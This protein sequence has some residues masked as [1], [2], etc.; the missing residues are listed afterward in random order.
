MTPYESASLVTQWISAV[1]AILA[2]AVAV[3][4]G[5]LTLLNNRRSK[6]AQ[7]RATFAAAG[8]GPAAA[9]GELAR[10]A[11][12]A[13]EVDWAVQAQGAEAWLL[14]NTGAATAYD[15]SLAGLTE[16]DRQRLKVGDITNPVRPTDVL[17]FD[18]VSRFSL[19]GP[20]N[21][22]VQ[23]ALDEG[24]PLSRRVLRVPAE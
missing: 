3:I 16:L 10:A 15:V 17:R 18:F 5:W 7:D 13:D 1:A 21:V 23:Y 24:G 11:V 2:V 19:S 8:A 6:D 14:R 20:G 12:V 9:P 22:V 4:F